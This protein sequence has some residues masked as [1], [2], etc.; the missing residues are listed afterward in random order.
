MDL[1]LQ[2]PSQKK[3]VIF[4]QERLFRRDLHLLGIFV[5]VCA[6][7]FHSFLVSSTTKRQLQRVEFGITRLNEI[8]GIAND[9]S[10]PGSKPLV[11]SHKNL[12][13]KWK[14]RTSR[15]SQ[16]NRTGMER[17]KGVYVGMR[18]IEQGKKCG[19]IVPD[20]AGYQAVKFELEELQTTGTL[21]LS[22][23]SE[24]EFY[25]RPNKKKRR[26]RNTDEREEDWAYCITRPGGG[27]I[28]YE[29]QTAG[30]IRRQLGLVYENIHLNNS[31]DEAKAILPAMYC[32]SRQQGYVH[33]FDSHL[34]YGYVITFSPPFRSVFFHIDDCHISGKRAIRRWTWVEF[35]IVLQ[36]NTR[37]SRAV[38]V[39]GP[40]QTVL[41]LRLL[42]FVFNSCWDDSII[43]VCQLNKDTT[44]KI[45]TCL[46]N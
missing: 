23:Y 26:T 9:I 2:M 20:Q 11:Y 42:C 4:I 10:A 1:W 3:S 13:L 35:V 15:L 38:H 5:V 6:R 16:L 17:Y 44:Q 34:L 27:L 18:K 36:H 25:V 39:T 46:P 12:S 19:E 21:G 43:L 40:N 28:T 30:V 7:N 24:V 33:S 14:D 8:F 37:H 29:Q 22:L 31:G 41:Q 32:D 45:I